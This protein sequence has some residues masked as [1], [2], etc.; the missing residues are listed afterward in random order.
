[1]DDCS[2]DEEEC[3]MRLYRIRRELDDLVDD[4]W[5]E[6]WSEDNDPLLRT[7]DSAEDA[8]NAIAPD[9]DWWW[10]DGQWMALIEEVP[11]G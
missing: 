3:E 6:S 4:E 2:L 8:K 5:V 7:F 9:A 10:E 11:R 1:M